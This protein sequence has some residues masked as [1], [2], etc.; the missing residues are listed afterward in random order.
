MSVRNHRLC[1]KS[2]ALQA[3]ETDLH[4]SLVSQPSFSLG[5]FNPLHTEGSLTNISLV[6]GVE[7][8]SPLFPVYLSHG[9]TMTSA[10]SVFLQTCLRP[11][12][13]VFAV[14]LDIRGERVGE[15]VLQEGTDTMC[16]KCLLTALHLQKTL[17]FN[18]FCFGF[19]VEWGRSSDVHLEL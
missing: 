8:C 4:L 16:E 12:D 19:F 3:S 11:M 2:P 13:C 9:F 6:L 5:V 10:K 17:S 7:T 14:C 18:L 15:A 1:H